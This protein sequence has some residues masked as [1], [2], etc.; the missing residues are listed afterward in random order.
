VNYHPAFEVN[1]LLF[2]VG[3]AVMW[4]AIT[5]GSAAW[6]GRRLR[7]AL[8]ESELVG[9]AKALEMNADG[10]CLRGAR[11]GVLV[12]IERD[13]RKEND[14]GAWQVQ[15][16]DPRGPGGLDFS[17]EGRILAPSGP[18]LVLGDAVFDDVVRV[19]SED[20]AVALASLPPTSR[21]A[22][23]DGVQKGWARHGAAWRLRGI[24]SVSEMLEIAIQQGLRLCAALRWD[25]VGMRHRLKV[26]CTDPCPEVAA[27]AMRIRF[28]RGW[29]DDDELPDLLHHRSPELSVRGA[30]ALGLVDWLAERAQRGT[31][32]ELRLR[33]AV[34]LHGLG[35]VDRLPM[36][37]E[38]LLI[39]GLGG[40]MHDECV[41]V[42]ADV[43]DA[44]ALDRLAGFPGVAEALRRIQARRASQMGGVSLAVDGGGQ[45]SVAE[46]GPEG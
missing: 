24:G 27:H 10:E 4:T 1:D 33:A 6:G 18:D 26:R 12:V 31:G 35:A 40:P 39:R 7:D 5:A 13:G 36:A 20:A 44:K 17:R 29:V 28:D 16:L 21:E 9:L 25:G 2:T 3:L 45:V 34:A 37:S 19:A 14:L 41:A 46:D 30:Q 32:M 42:L 8:G 38:A 23:R 43:G 22:I 11:R 15:L